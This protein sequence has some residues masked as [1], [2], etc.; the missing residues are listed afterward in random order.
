MGDLH[1]HP[2]PEPGGDYDSL[3]AFDRH[4][5]VKEHLL[6]ATVATALETTLAV[7]ALEAALATGATPAPESPD[8]PA[9]APPLIRM[10]QALFQGDGTAARAALPDFVRHFR[11]EPVLFQ[12]LAEGGHPRQVWRA[13]VAQGVLRA[14]L[15]NL[16]RLGLLRETF[17]LLRLA[18]A[19]EDNPS[20][21]APAGGRRVT[22]FDQLF[23]IALQAVAEAVVDSAAGWGEAGA[24]GQP[25]ADRLDPVVEPFLALWI[26]HSKTLRLSP[27]EAVPT[28]SD[29]DGLQEFIRR[30]GADLFHARFMTQAN[31]RGILHR[32]VGA[33]LDHLG[34]NPDPLHPVR[35][36][37][38]LDQVIPRPLAEQYLTWVL[39]A[40]VDNYEEYKDYNTTTTQSDYGEN[41]HLLLDFLQV[42]VAYE[43]DAWSFRPLVQVHEV[44]VR[45]GRRET[46]LMW[47]EEFARL[48][49][50]PAAEHLAE[51]AALEQDHG[52]KLRTV[53]DRL[54]EKFVKPLTLDRLCALVEPSMEE[55]RRGQG[56]SSFEQFEKEMQPYAADPAG[57]GLDLPH[58][59]RRL[60]TEVGRVRLSW[61]AIAGMATALVQVPRTLITLEDLNRQIEDWAKPLTAE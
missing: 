60:E 53:A 39:S 9:W 44:L 25:L 36:L 19:M 35:L 3:V 4:R 56:T 12:H 34:E 47:Q 50:E 61:T 33:Y 20:G 59:L 45:R 11:G 2:I 13:G 5:Q 14:L 7:G 27:L 52:M 42:K 40:V 31:L 54:A 26:E 10:E 1:Q 51:L 57:V 29:W 21:P 22:V 6:S 58:W 41:L 43:R 48:A 38:D 15:A 28:E 18:R 55:A 8:R 16:P 46:A 24:D 23:Q 49:E 32:G 30:Y 37:D 17:Q